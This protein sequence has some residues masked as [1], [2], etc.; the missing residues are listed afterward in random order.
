MLRKIFLM[1]GLPA[2]ILLGGC[3][4]YVDDFQYM[5]RPA[6]AQLP[7]ASP[8]QAPP[9]TVQASVIGV[10]HAD[11]KE[12]IPTCVEV[13]MQVENSGAQDV[14]FDPRT[15]ALTNGELL[16]FGPPLLRPP[17][18]MTLA[19]MQSVMLVTYFP[20][21]P[22]RSYDDTDL[23][24]L[25]LRWLVQIDKHTIG[26]VVYFRRVHYYYYDPYWAYPPYGFY[27]GVV[28]VHRR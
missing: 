26:Q 8:Q 3:S 25:Q 10:R 23:E 22:G 12:G 2:V 24:S 9:I 13:R 11:S 6:L 19:P 21:P 20:F 28:I 4:Q 14:V 7:P 27:G 1:L 15:L 16:S 18:P 17:Q 5:P